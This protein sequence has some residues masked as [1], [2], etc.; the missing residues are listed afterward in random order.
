[1]SERLNRQVAFLAEMDKLKEVVRQNATTGGRRENTA[2]HSWHIALFAMVIDPPE[3]GS[4]PFDR[5]KV[6]EMLQL[7]DVIEID[8]GDTFA[9]DE[10]GHADK[11]ARERLAADRLFSILPEDQCVRLR[12]VWDEFEDCETLEAQFASALDRIQPVLLNRLTGGGSWRRHGIRKGQVLSR[13]EIIK[14]VSPA[15]WELVDR[16]CDEGIEAGFLLP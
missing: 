8:A 16:W 2:E 10:A 14:T 4:A 15:L 9:Y 6:L 12:A 7:H 1:M 5:L 13:N 3:S 11:A